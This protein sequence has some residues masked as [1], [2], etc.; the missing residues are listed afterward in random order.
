VAVLL[1]DGQVGD[2]RLVGG[3]EDD[4]GPDD[5]SEVGG[6]PEG[7][8]LDRWSVQGVGPPAR[9]RTFWAGVPLPERGVDHREA[10][11]GVG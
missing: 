9:Q 2:P 3:V 5:L 4:A 6:D 1:G 10:G 11:L 7:R 8:G